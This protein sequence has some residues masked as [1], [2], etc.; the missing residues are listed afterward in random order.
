[1]AAHG[2]H[3]GP[4]PG[5][6]QHLEDEAPS[7]ADIATCEARVRYTQAEPAANAEKVCG[8][9]YVLDQGSGFGKVVQ[10]CQYNVYDQWCE[11]QSLTWTIINTVVA[12]GVVVTCLATDTGG[13]G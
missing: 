9:P 11:Y 1:M 12:E 8:T 6:C 3:P 10:D 2:C 7:G 4:A 13:A 5:N